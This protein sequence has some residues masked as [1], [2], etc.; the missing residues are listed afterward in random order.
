[1]IDGYGCDNSNWRLYSKGLGGAHACLNQRVQTRLVE[2]EAVAVLACAALL[3]STSN[4]PRL[5]RL[6]KGEADVQVR[7]A[8]LEEGVERRHLGVD[9]Q[10]LRRLVQTWTHTS[11]HLVAH[12]RAAC[13]LGIEELLNLGSRLLRLLILACIA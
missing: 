9:K 4:V 1:M 8:R 5:Q 7:V 6:E 11:P 10:R 3:P 13:T 2:L 12:R